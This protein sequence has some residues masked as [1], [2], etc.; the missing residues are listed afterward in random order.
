VAFVFDAHLAYAGAVPRL[1][2]PGETGTMGAG[3]VQ[4]AFYAQA[5][6]LYAQ[7]VLTDEPLGTFP[8]GT[9]LQPAEPVHQV[10]TGAVFQVNPGIAGDHGCGQ[11]HRQA[12]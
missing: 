9:V 12:A 2:A 1:A 10:T 3:F 8:A 5:F 6:N 11:N 4:P 7:I